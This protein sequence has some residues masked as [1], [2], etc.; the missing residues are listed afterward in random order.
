MLQRKKIDIRLLLGL[1]VGIVLL[2]QVLPE[3]QEKKRFEDLALGTENTAS[4]GRADGLAVHCYDLN[5]AHEC[6]KSYQRT[7]SGQKVLL[8]LGNSQVHAINQFKP[9]QETAAPDLHRRFRVNGEY[10]LTFS[11]PNASLQEHYLLFAYLINR[12]PIKTLVLPVVFDDMR[13]DGI[14]TSLIDAF[15]DYRTLDSLKSSEIGRILIENHGDQDVTGNELAALEETL[16]EHSEKALN[17]ILED[18]WSVWAERP[19]LRGNF[20]GW[21]YEFR[22]LVLGINPT[23]TRKMIRGRYAKNRDALIAVLELAASQEVKVLVYVV[24]LRNDV[25]VP[26]DPLEYASFKTE[27]SSL[28]RQNGS[29]FVDLENLVP[30]HLWGTKDSTT[31]GGGQELDFMHFQAG[32]HRLLANA[33]YNKLKNHGALK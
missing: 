24:P 21:L 12:L 2:Y 29:S 7:A 23:S 4:L 19:A 28:A 25:K 17:S 16:Q 14:R 15:K 9:G 31:I 33:L 5:D 27:M 13:E 22:N 18:A 6:L 32:G 11:Q 1:F 26:Y 30:A 3:E 10:F 8:W 20:M